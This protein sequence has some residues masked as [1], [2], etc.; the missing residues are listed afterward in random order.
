[1]LATNC[2]VN[3]VPTSTFWERE[4]KGEPGGVSVFPVWLC[5]HCN[6]PICRTRL[7]LFRKVKV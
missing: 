2:G 1:M 5:H 7:R 6:C 3:T 4:G